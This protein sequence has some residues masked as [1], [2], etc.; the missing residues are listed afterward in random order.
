MFLLWGGLPIDISKFQI[1]ITA[2]LF[3]SLY[4]GKPAVKTPALALYF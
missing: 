3:G 2:L 1:A 4:L